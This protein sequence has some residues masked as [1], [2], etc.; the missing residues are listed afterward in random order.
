MFLSVFEIQSSIFLAYLDGYHLQRVHGVNYGR[1][2]IFITAACIVVLVLATGII[3]AHKKKRRKN[4][5]SSDRTNMAFCEDQTPGR[6]VNFYR[7]YLV[8]KKKYTYWKVRSFF[9]QVK[10]E[11]TSTDDIG[12]IKTPEPKPRNRNKMSNSL[13]SMQAVN[14]FQ[15]LVS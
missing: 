11:G 12:A 1:I 2:F 3:L 10:T 4:S 15:K 5:I 9:L 13:L 7:Y 6:D 14:K 8:L